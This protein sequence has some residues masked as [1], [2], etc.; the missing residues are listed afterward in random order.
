MKTFKEHLNESEQKSSIH[1]LGWDRADNFTGLKIKHSEKIKIAKKNAKQIGVGSTRVAFEI[2]FKGK[3]TVMKI[4]NDCVDKISCLT[5]FCVVVIIAARP[6][7][8]TIK[9]N[10]LI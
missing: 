10:E 5:F 2:I 1:S 4:A 7:R 6:M 3:P 9:S 8:T